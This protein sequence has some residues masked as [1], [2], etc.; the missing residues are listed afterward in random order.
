MSTDQKQ[1]DT[2]GFERREAV[3]SI[4]DLRSRLKK[5]MEQQQAEIKKLDISL[6]IRG[7]WPDAFARGS[8][9]TRWQKESEAKGGRATLT[10]TNGLGEQKV[11]EESEV[12]ESIERPW[13]SN[14]RPARRPKLMPGS[15]AKMVIDSVR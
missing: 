14:D 10:I 2:T 3:R 15:K 8:C 6:D 7:L 13:L 11:F 9:R 12:P 5:L 1:H 4:S